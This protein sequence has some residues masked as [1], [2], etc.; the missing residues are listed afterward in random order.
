[1]KTTTSLESLLSG[2]KKEVYK[3][4]LA[5]I[6]NFVR[7]KDAEEAREKLHS[8]MLQLFVKGYKLN[9]QEAGALAK[10]ASE[11]PSPDRSVSLFRA[12]QERVALQR[13]LLRSEDARLARGYY[14]AAASGAL[15]AFGL[16]ETD[17]VDRTKAPLPNIP[18]LPALHSQDSRLETASKHKIFENDS[19]L[20]G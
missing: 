4:E 20:G 13:T 19:I 10:L 1:M 11:M 9:K 15:S 2:T 14:K 8:A 5:Q 17:V 6:R 7:G 16:R 18:T 3:E 12:L